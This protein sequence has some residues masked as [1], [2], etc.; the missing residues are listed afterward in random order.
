MKEGDI[1]ESLLNGTGYVVKK[2]VGSLVVL[3]SSK[4][5]SQILTGA[6][7]PRKITLSGKGGN[8]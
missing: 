5:D 1:F 8:V 6:G 2:I 7:T 3:R 4:G